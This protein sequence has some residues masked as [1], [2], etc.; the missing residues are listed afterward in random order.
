MLWKNGD[1]FNHIEARLFSLKAEGKVRSI[2][3]PEIELFQV[4]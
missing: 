1:R 2:R 3:I 4:V